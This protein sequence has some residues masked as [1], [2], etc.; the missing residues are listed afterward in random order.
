MRKLINKEIH[1]VQGAGLASDTMQISATSGITALASLAINPSSFVAAVALDA[2]LT[3]IAT[4]GAGAAIAGGACYLVG[5]GTYYN[6]KDIYN[7]RKQIG[8][9]I[10]TFVSYATAPLAALID[11]TDE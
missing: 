7:N 6:V 5:L 9:A 2:G 4:V 1:H 11:A 8:S 3:G 10:E